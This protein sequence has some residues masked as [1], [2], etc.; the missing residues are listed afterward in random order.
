M[1]TVIPALEQQY[2]NQIAQK[3]NTEVP[4]WIISLAVVSGSD[5]KRKPSQ[6]Q[7]FHLC[8]DNKQSFR[9]QKNV[10]FETEQDQGGPTICL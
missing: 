7:N 3:T 8:H 9:M 4:V 1:A 2:F 10:C 6:K 5:Q